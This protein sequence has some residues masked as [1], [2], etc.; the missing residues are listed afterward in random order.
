MGEAGRDETLQWDWKAATSVLRNL[1]YSQAEKNFADRGRWWR[2]LIGKLGAATEAISA[3]PN[4][5][6]TMA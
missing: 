6:T 3:G 1:Q 2:A 4:Y 5:N